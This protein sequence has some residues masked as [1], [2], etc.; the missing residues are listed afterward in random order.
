MQVNIPHRPGACGA[1]DQSC[2]NFNVMAR[3]SAGARSTSRFL[4]GDDGAGCHFVAAGRFAL[5]DREGGAIPL[6]RCFGLP[7][8]PAAT[9][10][11]AR[12]AFLAEAASLLPGTAWTR[13]VQLTKMITGERIATGDVALALRCAETG[14]CCRAPPQA[15]YRL[16]DAAVAE[17]EVRSVIQFLSELETL[18]NR[19]LDFPH[20]ARVGRS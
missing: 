7:S 2:F 5:F 20:T 18:K 8:R 17:A 14:P 12:D 19:H 9:A 15:G 3:E 13:A 11:A 1:H 4:A 6:A 16:A 10:R